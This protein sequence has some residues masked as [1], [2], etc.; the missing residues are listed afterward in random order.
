MPQIVAAISLVLGAVFIILWFTAKRRAEAAS[1]WPAAAGVI[2]KSELVKHTTR[3]NGVTSTSFEPAVEYEYH[4]MGQAYTGKRL[5]F[6]SKLLAYDKAEQVIAKYP[7]EAQVQVFYNPEK[8]ADAILECTA[9]GIGT[10][11]IF[12]ILLIVVGLAGLVISLL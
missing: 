3:H 2:L 11:L 12:G 5:T 4:V 9:Q 10:Q 6:G 8:P 1:A 7:A